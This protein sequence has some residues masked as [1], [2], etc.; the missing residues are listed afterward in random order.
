MPR[1]DGAFSRERT[2]SDKTLRLGARTVRR[3]LRQVAPDRSMPLI[4][5]PSRF[6]PPKQSP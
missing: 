5:G 4:V 2:V 3:L 1:L 6:T